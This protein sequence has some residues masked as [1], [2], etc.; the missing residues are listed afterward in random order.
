MAPEKEHSVVGEQATRNE[1]TLT[2]KSDIVLELQQPVGTCM[3][4][5]S[6]VLCLASSVFTALMGPRF[7]EGQVTGSFL[8]PRTIALSDDDAVGIT[9]PC[10]LLHFGDI[11]RGLKV[12]KFK[13][14]YDAVRLLV[15][16]AVVGNK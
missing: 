2:E 6:A 14:C 16:L 13:D 4:V 15:R 10:A 5:S 7:A 1:V 9:Y 8:H 3:R 12:T 11:E